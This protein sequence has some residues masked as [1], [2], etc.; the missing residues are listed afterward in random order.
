[1]VQ[2][3]ILSESHILSKS[4]YK[5]SK[6]D[7][8]DAYYYQFGKYILNRRQLKLKKL[9]IKYPGHLGPVAGFPSTQISDTF[10][11]LIDDILDVNKINVQTQKDLSNKEAELFDKLISKCGLVKALDYQYRTKDLNDYMMRFE[12]L[13]GS[14]LAGNEDVKEEFIDIINLLSNPAIQKISKDDAKEMIKELI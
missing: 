13:R 11:S 9:L 3:G 10:K 2:T 8:K 14:Y 12:I 5:K 1:M 4:K 6:P 7:F